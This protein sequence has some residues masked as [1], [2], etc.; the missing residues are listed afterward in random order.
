MRNTFLVTYDVSND[1]RLRRV[2]KTMCGFGDHL[3]YSV[4]ECQFSQTNLG[5]CHHALGKLIHHQDDQV[6][7]VDLEMAVRYSNLPEPPSPLPSGYAAL[8]YL[9][10]LR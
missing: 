3:Q 7:F 5:R 8:L 10:G 9:Y 1:L 4:F 6:L 2:H